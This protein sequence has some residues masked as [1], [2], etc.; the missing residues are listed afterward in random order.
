MK[1]DMRLRMVAGLIRPG[2]PLADIGTD[3]AYLPVFLVEND[4]IPKALA[5]D[6]KIGPLENAKKTINKH[7]LSDKITPVLSD[8]L[9]EIPHEYTDFCIAG[10]GGEL[11]AK[12]LEESPWVRRQ[13]NHFVFQPQTH[14]EDLR[15]H[16]LTNGYEIIREDVVKERMKYYLAIEA[17]C[18]GVTE[19]HREADYYIGKLRET[20]SI[21]KG[22]YL[23]KVASR[24]DVKLKATRDEKYGKLIDEILE[25][26]K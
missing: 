15:R 2:I 14:P 19:E 4:I 13:G 11:I 26:A 1:L 22:K 18:T 24:L 9:K 23:E 20:T 16:L 25:A 17:V 3:H 5:S 8:G 12:I 21:H 6:V 7:N 10:M